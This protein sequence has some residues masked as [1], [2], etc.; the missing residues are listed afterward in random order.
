MRIFK[1]TIPFFYQC[2]KVCKNALTNYY[3]II[4][5]DSRIHFLDLKPTY[6]STCGQDNDLRSNFLMSS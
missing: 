1:C 2:T 4:I 5:D 3:E 6:N